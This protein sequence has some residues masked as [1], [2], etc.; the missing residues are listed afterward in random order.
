MKDVARSWRPIKSIEGFVRR[1][2]SR[3]DAAESM[4]S[5]VQAVGRI[6]SRV[7]KWEGSPCLCAGCRQ[8]GVA[9]LVGA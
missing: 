4:P 6:W 9:G 2:L 5:E 1:S 3:V 7:L 8:S